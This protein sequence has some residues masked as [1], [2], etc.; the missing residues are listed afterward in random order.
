MAKIK[1]SICFN[2]QQ[3]PEKESER[4]H[5]LP[6]VSLMQPSIY[7]HFTT[8]LRRLSPSIT[9][10]ATFLHSSP[11]TG[12]RHLIVLPSRKPQ[13]LTAAAVVSTNKTI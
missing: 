5:L 7:I 2:K 11:H 12:T 3:K 8:Y 6:L 9:T 1:T 10:A 4:V 13:C